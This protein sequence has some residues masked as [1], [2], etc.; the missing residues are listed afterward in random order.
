MLELLKEQ[1][2]AANLELVRRGLVMC[3]WGNASAIDR[4]RRLVVIKPSGVPYESMRPELMVVVD[5]DGNIVEA[6][7]RPSS[8]T[9]THLVLYK[10]FDGIGA[11]AH[12]HSHYATCWAQARRP[13]PCFGTTH[14]DYFCGG[15]PVTDEMSPEEIEKDYE[16]NT[17]HVI[18]RCFEHRDPMACPAVLVSS[19]A[20]FTWGATLE[21]A[22]ENAV[23]LEE[24]ARMALHTLA[25]EPL[26]PAI[27]S[28][29]LDKH[30]L[31]KHGPGA[32]YGQSKK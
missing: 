3:T 5:L 23:V 2:C 4:A 29:L 6:D 31:R 1:V 21:E 9:E 8:D 19:H 18:T 14:A 27:D 13:I 16:R 26:T 15:V 10:A 11:I 17:G 22:V 32:Y 25:L 20:P 7:L 28:P 12:T 30:F 24:V